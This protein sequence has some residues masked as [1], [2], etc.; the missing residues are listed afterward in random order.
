[1]DDHA[2]PKLDATPPAGPFGPHSFGAIILIA[3]GALLFL[4]NLGVLPFANIGAYWPMALAAWG[5]VMLTR[6][7][8]HCNMVWPWTFIAIGVLLTLGNLGILRVSIGSLWPLF[9][10]AAGVSMLFRRTWSF[11]NWNGDPQYWELRH[12]YRWQRRE[13]RWRQRQA[14]WQ[15]RGE[16]KGF[17]PPG[18]YSAGFTSQAS[19]N[20][21]AVHQAVVFSSMKR[22][23]ENPNF[24]SAKFDCVF[25]EL[26]I[27]LRGCTITTPDRRAI[28]EANA[29]FGAIKFRIPETWKVVQLGAAV[30]GAFE[31]RTLPPRPVAG[32]E[33]PTLVLTGNA[34]FG[35]VE[36]DN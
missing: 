15:E 23:I 9:L 3:V 17:V 14:R 1:M 19:A 28:V 22:R 26:K 7:R 6:P 33:P 35:A 24:E 20:P 30:F 21:N 10:I 29:S 36:V 27:D 25:G 5:A 31:D 18:Q 4:D 32:E 34:S 2:E 13:Q 12:Q 16:R 11:R 8:S